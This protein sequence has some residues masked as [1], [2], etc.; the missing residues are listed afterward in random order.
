MKERS[1]IPAAAAI[2]I[3]AGLLAALSAVLTPIARQNTQ[4]ERQEMMERLLPGSTV[5][6]PEGT[7][8][9]EIITAVYK[10]ERGYVVETTTQGYAGD[11]VLM[12]GVD[13]S[14]T[15]TGVV[16][17]DM[18]ET[19]GLGRNALRDVPFLSQFLGSA[20]Q[21]EIGDNVDVLTGATVTTKAIIKGVNAASDFVT[22]A[23]IDSGA[24]QWEG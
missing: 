1:W 9:E 24:T 10:G 18:E 3:S 14:G 4:N 19:W 7:G 20:G 22:G 11:V 23:D 16:V 17:R 13:N 12:V 5:F 6:V 15:V 8:G 2:G 21:L